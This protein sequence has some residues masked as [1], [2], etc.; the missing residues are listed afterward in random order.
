[1]PERG[2]VLTSLHVALPPIHLNRIQLSVTQTHAVLYFFD[3][4]DPSGFIQESLFYYSL[5]FVLK[6]SL[7]TTVNSICLGTCS[8]CFRLVWLTVSACLSKRVQKYNF[9][10]IS[11]CFLKVFW[12]FRFRFLSFACQDVKNLFVVAGAKYHLYTTSSFWSFFWLFAVQPLT[13]WIRFE[14]KFFFLLLGTLK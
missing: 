7:K 8:S 6:I 4:R 13:R 3:W 5:F 1:V 9:F 12:N 10:S 11:K 2:R 14:A